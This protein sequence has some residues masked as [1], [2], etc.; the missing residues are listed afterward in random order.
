MDNRVKAL[1]D[2]VRETALNVGGAAGS[3]ARMATRAA[4]QM[5]DLAKLNMRMFDLNAESTQLLR[6][7]GQV[8]YDTHLG[9]DTGTEAITGLLTELDETQTELTEL[10]ERV[11]ALRSSRECPQCRSLCA[12]GD[13]F[14]HNCGT[15]LPE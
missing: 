1:L 14:C 11:T 6:R 9:K 4:G 3:T 5:A 13:H 7:L 12:R 2:R 15:R 10:K 8:V